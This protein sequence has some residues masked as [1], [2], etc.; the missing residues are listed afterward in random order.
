MKNKLFMKGVNSSSKETKPEVL[1][2]SIH[3]MIIPTHSAST[4]C[5]PA[6]LD[7]FSQTDSIVASAYRSLC[8]NRYVRC[9]AIDV[10]SAAELASIPSAIEGVNSVELGI[11]RFQADGIRVSLDVAVKPDPLAYAETLS[12]VRHYFSSRIAA[13]SFNLLS[14][15]RSDIDSLLSGIPMDIRSSND[16]ANLYSVFD[17]LDSD[18]ILLDMSL[19]SSSASM[20]TCQDIL[21]RGNPSSEE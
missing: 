1:R 7:L 12:A 16:V 2:G 13:C 17:T 3:F 8:V 9:L 15:S 14:I 5:C 18:S 11:L 19:I 6:Y 20:S 21:R 10:F 4:R